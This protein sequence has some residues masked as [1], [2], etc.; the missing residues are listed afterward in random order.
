MPAAMSAQALTMSMR[1]SLW[2]LGC[3]SVIPSLLRYELAAG[4]RTLRPT[5]GPVYSE[6]SVSSIDPHT[7]L[8]SAI[9]GGRRQDQGGD[10]AAEAALEEEGD[11]GA[12]N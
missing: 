8:Q 7:V 2:N 10:A 1:L 6:S 5:M 12:R 4:R 3:G 11:Q 9:G